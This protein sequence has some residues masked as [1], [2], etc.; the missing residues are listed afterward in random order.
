MANQI[1]RAKAFHALHVRGRPLVLYNIWDAGSAVAVAAAGA[2][3]IATGS[4]SVAMA[5]GYADGEAIPLDVALANAARIVAA[6]RLPVTL[7]FERGYGTDPASVG[8]SIAAALET[9][10]VGCNIE[11]S[12]AEGGALRDAA[13]QAERLAAARAAADRAGVPLFIN[14]RT[15]VFFTKLADAH[16]E[17]MVADALRRARLYA[18]AG[19]D[20]LFVPLLVDERLI[21]RLVAASPLPVNIMA[22]GSA[23]PL[24]RLAALGVARVSYGPGPYRLAMSALEGAAREVLGGAN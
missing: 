12:L 15:D 1:E 10:I 7:D 11:D 19:A 4:A 22:L 23:P 21:G 9:G 24:E 2:S 13:A 5:N 16:D 8:D 6:T 20:G 18:E 3:A 14:A 17:A